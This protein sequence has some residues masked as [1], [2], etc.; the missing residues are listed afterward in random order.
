MHSLI[1]IVTDAL[2]Q[3]NKCVGGGDPREILKALQN[4][5]A[6]LPFPYLE[7]TDYYSALIFEKSNGLPSNTTVIAALILATFLAQRKFI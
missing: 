6:N 5:N 4:P 2:Q 3:I 7:A 1:S